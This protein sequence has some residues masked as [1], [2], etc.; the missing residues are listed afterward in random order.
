MGTAE[1][2]GRMSNVDDELCTRAEALVGTVLRGKYTVE[3]VIGIGGMA[4][5]YAAS[6]RN[7]RR[8]ALKLLHPELSIRADLRKRFLREAQ[9][10]NAVSHP[11]VV[12]IIDD[13][14]AEDGAAF[15]VMEL[16]EGQNVEELWEAHGQ[17]LPAKAVLTLAADLCGVLAVAHDAGVIHRDL[18]PANLF[19]TH[20]GELK[21]LDFG[22]ARVRDTAGSATSTGSVFGTPA[23]M[24]PEQAGGLVNELGPLTDVWAVGATMYTLLSGRPVHDGQS[25][26][27]IAVLAATRPAPSLADVLP[28]AP[29]EVVAIVDRALAFDKAD[30]WASAAEMRTALAEAMTAL[31]EQEL[32]DDATVVRGT[33]SETM[34][35]VAGVK[36]IGERSGTLASPGNEAFLGGTTGQPVSSAPITEVD[37]TL[38][39]R[40]PW[41]RG[42][43]AIRSW[44]LQRGR[45]VDPASDEAPTRRRF[46]PRLGVLGA[47]VTVATAAIA[48]VSVSALIGRHTVASIPPAAPLELAQEAAAAATL[49]PES[50]TEPVPPVA[51]S[52]ASSEVPTPRPITSPASETTSPRPVVSANTRWTK[53]PAP[54]PRAT[55]SATPPRL[56]CNPPFTVEEG[57]RVHKPGCP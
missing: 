47:V 16:L 45:G 15:L 10:A 23:F 50:P 36:A 43:A 18:K 12:A 28:D 8:V 49:P 17:R 48:A 14:V 52:A 3:R 38:T 34:L 25:G 13:D 7:G 31:A 29:P 20:A 54:R 33:L 1:G 21:V 53:A 9:A 2:V 55:A 46:S 39:H 11:G 30:R 35:A 24:A 27:H 44:F 37:S 6:H 57:I 5:V 26:Q 41:K 51:T 42:S 19:V 40:S 32:T 4:S 56:N 22:I